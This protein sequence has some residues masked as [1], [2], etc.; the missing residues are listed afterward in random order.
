MLAKG[1]VEN[2]IEIKKNGEIIGKRFIRSEKLKYV[3]FKSPNEINKWIK[4]IM[5]QNMYQLNLY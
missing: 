3:Y 5:G 1:I 4:F 2:K